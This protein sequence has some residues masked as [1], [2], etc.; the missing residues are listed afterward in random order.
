M[1]PYLLGA[2]AVGALV[3][4][5]LMFH[6]NTV[7]ASDALDYFTLASNLADGV[8]YEEFGRPTAFWPV[9]YPALLGLVFEIIG[10]E[11]WVAKALNLVLALAAIPLLYLLGVVLYGRAVARPASWLLALLPSHVFFTNLLIPEALFTTLQLAV[12]LL[13]VAALRDGSRRSQAAPAGQGKALL[14]GFFLVPALGESEESLG[15]ACA[16]LIAGLAAWL[17]RTQRNLLFWL[18]AGTLVGYGLLVRPAALALALAVLATLCVAA[19]QQKVAIGAP[20]ALFIVS[21]GLVIAPWIVRNWT[22]IG[23]GATLA[24]NGGYNLMVGNNAGANGCAT[25]PIGASRY[26]KEN[27]NEV[28]ADREAFG[29]AVSFMA[30]N[31]DRAIALVPLRLGCLWRDDDTAAAKWH[32]RKQPDG[33]GKLERDLWGAVSNWYYLG[34]LGLAGLGIPAWFRRTPEHLL[35]VILVAVTTLV[36]LPFFGGDRFHQSLLPYVA[37]WAAVGIATVPRWLRI[38]RSR[39][40]EGE[41]L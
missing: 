26:N 13:V 3:R 9:G 39:D 8:G 37:L 29:D 11:V 33:L 6:I 15:L 4:L 41:G 19:R 24:T 20:A 14:G 25:F 5:A 1:D 7:P 31:P 12:V 28:R 17:A 2:V 18:A 21:A 36:Y 23:A 27:P 30:D 40:L 10:N 34:L 38:S 22:D 16:A 32:F 35:P